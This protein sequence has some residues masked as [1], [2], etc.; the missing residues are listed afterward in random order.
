MCSSICKCTGCK[1]YEESPDEKKQLNVLN[2]TDIGNKGGNSPGLT[3]TF[4]TL[5]K[6]KKDRWIFGNSN[7]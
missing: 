6:L 7:A 2:Y 5:P 4:K 3:S 1:N